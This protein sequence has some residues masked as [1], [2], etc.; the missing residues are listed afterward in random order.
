MLLSI[1]GRLARVR[2]KPGGS[3]PGRFPHADLFG[4]SWR[5]IFFVNLPVALFS[6]VAVLF[7]VPETR[8]RSAGRPD[9]LGAAFLTAALVAIVYPL[10]EGRQLGWPA[11][12]WLLLAAGVLALAALGM[13]EDRRRH[14]DLTP[15]LRTR[16]FR[17]PAFTAGLTV[18]LLFSAGLQGFFLIFALWMQTGQGFSPLHLLRSSVARFSDILYSD[19]RHS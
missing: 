17:V 16:L 14:T 1:C 9:L 5:S 12:G 10:L 6:L 18:Q 19:C 2:R 15:L 3:Q 4:W 7:L 11:W 13:I 8:E